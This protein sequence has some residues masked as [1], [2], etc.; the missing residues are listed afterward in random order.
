MLRS[1]LTDDSTG[2]TG[3]EDLPEQLRECGVREPSVCVMEEVGSGVSN[4]LDSNSLVFII[5]PVIYLQQLR[6][7]SCGYTGNFMV[8]SLT[9]TDLGDER[10]DIA[11]KG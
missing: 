4:L 3:G 5:Y 6:I 10:E 2:Y 9:Y 11:V 7:Y 8:C 1:D